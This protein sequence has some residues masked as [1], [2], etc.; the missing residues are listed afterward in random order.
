MKMTKILGI[1][2]GERRMGL[3]LSSVDQ[4]YAFAYETL[5]NGPD[6]LKRL[7]E[8]ISLENVDCVVV[9]LPLGLSGKETPQTRE[10]KQFV[11]RLQNT[12]D[13]P[14]EWQ[15]ERFSSKM[16]MSLFRGTGI[17]KKK[18]KIDEGSARII[19]QDFLDKK[20]QP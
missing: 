4:K 8:I 7:K 20:N 18:Q 9:G 15:D 6:L 13:V 17:K 5:E 19:L 12:V 16:T 2:Y 3:A 11:E 10:V 14:I 1:D